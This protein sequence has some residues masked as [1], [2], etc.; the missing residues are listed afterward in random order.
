M[1]FPFFSKNSDFSLLVT[2]FMITC[3]HMNIHR[4]RLW[5]LCQRWKNRVNR[6]HLKFRLHLHRGSGCSRTLRDRPRL[7]QLHLPFD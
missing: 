3:V 5:Y 7:E 4:I 6:W 1:H 2:L